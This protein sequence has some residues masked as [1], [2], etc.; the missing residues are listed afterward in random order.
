VKPQVSRAQ[1]RLIRTIG[2]YLCRF[3]KTSGTDDIYGGL[4]V[5]QIVSTPWSSL[6]FTGERHLLSVRLPG[7][8]HAPDDLDF[9]TLAVPGR[10]VAVRDATW[11]VVNDDAVLKLDLLELAEEKEIFSSR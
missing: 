11:A 3:G 7:M 8:G 10:I 2:L 9:T 4:V 5:E 6:T 1:G